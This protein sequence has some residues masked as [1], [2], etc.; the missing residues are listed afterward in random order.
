MPPNP[1]QFYEFAD[2]C[3]DRSEKVLL[4]RGTP[5]PLTPKVF[6]TLEVLVENT[7]KLL[8]KDELIQRLWQD[9]FVD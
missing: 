3:L 2:F 1:T 4:R 9:Q 7:G 6:D 8:K 5:V